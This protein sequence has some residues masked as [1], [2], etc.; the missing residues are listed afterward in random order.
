[1]THVRTN[2]FILVQLHFKFQVNVYVQV[3]DEKGNRYSSYKNVILS[4]KSY[5]YWYQKWP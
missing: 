3:S 4:C 2:N 5:R 1:M